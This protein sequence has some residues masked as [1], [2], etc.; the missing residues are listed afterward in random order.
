MG[1]T[2]SI[3]TRSE[4]VNTNQEVGRI[5]QAGDLG[6]SFTSTFL[7]SPT[8]GVV[9][10][11]S[12]SKR[13]SYTCS[14]HTSGNEAKPL[15]SDSSQLFSNGV[16]F[17]CLRPQ[18]SEEQQNIV[19]D[20]WKIIREDMRRTGIVT[21]LSLFSAHPEMLPLFAKFRGIPVS[22]IES[23]VFFIE[24]VLIV[25]SHVE[26]VIARLKERD[27]LESLLHD[28]GDIHRKARVTRRYFVKIMPFFVNAIKPA[29]DVWT[30][31]LEQ[32]WLRF[33]QLMC[34]VICEKMHP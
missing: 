15:L 25:M 1:K 24:H 30:E 12:S 4:E 13:T 8:L 29:F 3:C 9:G 17:A 32:S 11:D 19:L 2:L 16:A 14:G 26:K 6:S 23:N 31:E 7:T 27:T 28:I 21:F 5:C 33:M 20:S 18:L 22:S 34:H 10:T